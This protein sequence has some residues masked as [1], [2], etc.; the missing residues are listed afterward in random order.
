MCGLFVSNGKAKLLFGDNSKLDAPVRNGS[1][2]LQNLLDM[3]PV[4]STMQ[5]I[6]VSLLNMEYSRTYSSRNILI[7][8]S[9][10]AELQYNVSAN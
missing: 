6:L 7:S 1:I 2:S 10:L 3:G 4:A 8:G 5:Q 9:T